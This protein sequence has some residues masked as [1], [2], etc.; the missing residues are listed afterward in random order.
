MESI[1]LP[2]RQRMSEGN[3]DRTIHCR[4]ST[5]RDPSYEGVIQANIELKSHQL[6]ILRKCIEHEN[7][8]LATL[9]DAIISEKY[10]NVKTD[11]GILGDKVGSGKSFVILAL[12]LV[13]PIPRLEYPITSSYGNGHVIMEVMN[14]KWIDKPINI[15]VVSHILLKQWSN[16]IKMFSDN[17][18]CYVVN[19]KKSVDNLVNEVDQ[20]DIFLVTGTFYRYVCGVFYVNNWRANRLVFDEVDSMNAPSSHFMA[21]RFYW[22][23]TAS[24]KNLLFPTHRIYYDRR[25]LSNSY[26]I[27][28]G[29]L[30]NLFVKNLF[31]NMTKY[32]G[33]TET[34]ILDRM[35]IKNTDDYID[36]S[37][38][39]PNPE[40]HIIPC[41]SPIEVNI[42]TG[43]VSND[44]I[45]CLNAGDFES[46][47]GYINPYNVDTEENII[48]HALSDLNKNLNNIKVRLTAAE[49]L[50]YN[51]EEQKNNTIAKLNTEKSN[52]NEKITLMKNRIDENQLCI[53]CYNEPENKCISKCCKNSFCFKCISTWLS[54][55][56]NCPLCKTN[57][58]IEEDFYIVQNKEE[59]QANGNH[60]GSF[61]T[62][63]QTIPTN[64]DTTKRLNK[65]QNLE[66]L[67][68]C[69]KSSSKFLIFSDFEQSF[70]NMYKHL[71]ES[72]LRYANIKG[73]SVNTTLQKYRGTELDALL[74][75]SKNYGSGLNLENTTDLVLFHKFESQLEKQVIGRAQRPGRK[76]PLRIW[77]FVNENEM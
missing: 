62:I 48:T 70:H 52:I 44:I 47:I 11:I 33:E 34:R 76:V 67:I 55:N 22:L 59:Q 27:S 29:I 4:E 26:I 43:V 31:T 68:N 69:R 13:N 49:Q 77:Y 2:P 57:I 10:T 23:V 39:L 45:N 17:L 73:N 75:N 16:Y 8:G 24:Y 56:H 53:I 20:N 14:K 12:I 51:T 72:G 54:N 6:T 30:N 41:R 46:A 60:I 71:D 40:V 35:I 21:A 28:N 18:R 65:F 74:V 66:R 19:K 64:D 61:K 9:D 50:T 32:M 1:L 63:M 5:A 58:N 36:E 25:N 37:F 42:L 7:S 38:V 15:I 3:I